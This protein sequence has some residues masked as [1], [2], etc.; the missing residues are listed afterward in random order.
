MHALLWMYISVV[1]V[2]I[3]VIIHWKNKSKRILI[4]FLNFK[5]K[6]Q[7]MMKIP[8]AIFL[9]VAPEARKEKIYNT[10][11]ALWLSQV[12]YSSKYHSV[13]TCC[14]NGLTRTHC[15]D[16]PKTGDPNGSVPLMHFSTCKKFGGSKDFSSAVTTSYTTRKT[17]LLLEDNHQ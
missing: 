7:Y 12:H 1:L 6:K 11:E 10:S 13:W 16:F 17:N 4:I 5:R 8:L 2:D 3:S 14:N 9:V 15:T